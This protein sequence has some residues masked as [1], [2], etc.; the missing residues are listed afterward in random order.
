MKSSW[1]IV[2][3]GFM[4]SGKTTV[5]REVARRLGWSFV[6]TDD[7]IVR[8]AGKSI[9]A[10]FAD[11][12]EEHFRCLENRVVRK[13]AAM[14]ETV[15]AT[16]GG[17]VKNA[18]NLRLLAATGVLFWLQ[19]EPEEIHRRISGQRIIRPLLEVPDPLGEIRSLLRER[20]SYYAQADFTVN[21]NGTVDAV[22]CMIIAKM[23]GWRGR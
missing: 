23:N 10:I 9:A 15:I 19:L 2:L 13:L 18:D 8:Q 5:G 3:V 14:K 11:E 12:G 4:G 22:A 21:A 17:V 16:G 20:E 1:N 6:D 7:E